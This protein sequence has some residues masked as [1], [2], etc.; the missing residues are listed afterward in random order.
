MMIS[1]HDLESIN[2]I[3]KSKLP[4]PIGLRVGELLIGEAPPAAEGKVDWTNNEF[5]F[6]TAVE[7]DWYKTEWYYYDL[8]LYKT[9]F[10]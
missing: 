4:E 7:Y 10:K 3:D 6:H 2:Q 8:W 1:L 5:I 9:S